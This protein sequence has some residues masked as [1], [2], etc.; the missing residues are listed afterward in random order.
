MEHFHERFCENNV[1]KCKAARV[2]LNRIQVNNNTS[3]SNGVTNK[4]A[5]K[6]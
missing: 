1:I 4:R 3:E 5:K 2:V 6:E